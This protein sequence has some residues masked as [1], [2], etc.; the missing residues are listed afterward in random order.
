MAVAS[1]G[2]ILSR[3]RTTKV[4]I[5]LRGSGKSRFYHDVAQLERNYKKLIPTKG[6]YTSSKAVFPK[7]KINKND[8]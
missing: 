4:L 1:T 2:I 7:T 5:R 6:K 8:F 3:Q